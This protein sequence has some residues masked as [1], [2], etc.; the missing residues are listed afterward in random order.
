MT[1]L[2]HGAGA[3]VLS[4]ALGVAGVTAART[5]PRGLVYSTPS[6]DVVQRQPAPGACRPIGVGLYSRPDSVCTPGAVNPVVT[7][8]TI[9][10]TICR[11]G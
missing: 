6:G 3:W 8:A 2:V 7:Q 1:T 9:G 4:P 5:A 10:S 11:S